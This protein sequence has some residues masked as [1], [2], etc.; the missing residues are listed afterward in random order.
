LKNN[1]QPNKKIRG[2]SFYS[3]NPLTSEAEQTGN[4][5]AGQIEAKGGPRPMEY[6]YADGGGQG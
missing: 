2:L 3:L 5:L 1:F 6:F 4:D